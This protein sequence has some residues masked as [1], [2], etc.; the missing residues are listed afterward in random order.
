MDFDCKFS[1]A[2]GFDDSYHETSEGYPCLY[3][4]FYYLYLRYTYPGFVPND[5][6][7]LSRF[8]WIVFWMYLNAKVDYLASWFFAGVTGLVSEPCSL[9]VVKSS[10]GMVGPC[11]RV[12]YLLELVIIVAERMVTISFVACLLITLRMV[13]FLVVEAYLYFYLESYFPM[14]NRLFFLRLEPWVFVFVLDLLQSA[15]MLRI[16]QDIC[17][18]NSL[19]LCGKRR[20]K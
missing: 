18:W 15:Y 11:L 1:I 8:S 3:S 10:V 13:I 12:N 2:V 14:V 5:C 4:S 9:V 20:Q 19:C 16:L 6:S 7:Y 17:F